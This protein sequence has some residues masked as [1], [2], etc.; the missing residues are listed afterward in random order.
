MSYNLFVQQGIDSCVQVSTVVDDLA[1]AQT[2]ATALRT[3]SI[4][5]PEDVP[6][7]NNALQGNLC[8]FCIW[9]MG[10]RL[11][12][13]YHRA[14]TWP[15]NADSPWR[16]SSDPGIDILALTGVDDSLSLIIVEAKSS[17]KNG[18]NLIV[19]NS[20]TLQTDFQHLFA[21]HVQN[22][23][24]TRVGDI[25]F[26]F[27]IRRSRPDLASRI[28][29]LVG[30]SPTESPNIKL[31]GVLICS[32]GNES[33]RQSRISAFEQL[34]AHLRTQGWSDN[35]IEF[36]CIEVTN[37]VKWIVEVVDRSVNGSV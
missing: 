33:S 29:S 27:T 16:P 26:E 3:H 11:W 23:L 7:L 25:L 10:D 37:F 22:R 6:E 35:Q 2:I 31:V 5:P 18:I 12:K 8:E 13:I 19:G 20:S 1:F 28:H 32:R 15:S 9:D 34:R 17:Q 14:N 21:G 36:R 4:A 30:K 24:L